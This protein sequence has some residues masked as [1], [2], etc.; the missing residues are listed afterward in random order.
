[1]HIIAHGHW[2]PDLLSWSDLRMLAAVVSR[3]RWS[4]WIL[5]GFWSQA[6]SMFC[7]AIFDRKRMSPSRV[8]PQTFGFQKCFDHSLAYLGTSLD[9]QSS[10]KPLHSSMAWMCSMMV[11]GC[12]WQNY[13]CWTLPTLTFQSTVPNQEAIPCPLWS[14]CDQNFSEVG[15]L[16]TMDFPSKK[17]LEVQFEISVWMKRISVKIGIKVRAPKST[18][19]PS[20][21]LFSST[22]GLY[23]LSGWFAFP[24]TTTQL[25][26]KRAG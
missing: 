13:P 22:R 25:S 19:S 5:V 14:R 15:V 20:S 6:D 26:L 16:P 1:M 21:W 4:A 3:G 18:L 12:S 10:T 8:C 11:H 9:Q 24:R 23:R 17:L 2:F 7:K